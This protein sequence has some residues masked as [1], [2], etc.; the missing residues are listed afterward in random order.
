MTGTV[1]VLG[2]SVHK[3]ARR[4]GGHRQEGGGWRCRGHHSHRHWGATP[5][6]GTGRMEGSRG[7]PVGTWHVPVRER[8][9]RLEYRGTMEKGKILYNFFTSPTYVVVVSYIVG[10]DRTRKTKV[11]VNWQ[12]MIL[13]HFT[14][15][16]THHDC[17]LRRRVQFSWTTITAETSPYHETG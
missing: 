2:S 12:H 6:W 13:Q 1:P 8:E 4:S 16:V 7:S 14:I 17:M 5:S 10:G 3:V 9:R 11:L 15:I